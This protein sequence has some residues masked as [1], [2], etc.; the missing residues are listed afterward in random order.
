MML[1]RQSSQ[2]RTCSSPTAPLGSELGDQSYLQFMEL[3][4]IG[5]HR[6]LELPVLQKIP[7]L[8]P[9]FYL[10]RS[11]WYGDFEQRVSRAFEDANSDSNH[12]LA[13]TIRA[14]TSL[15]TQELANQFSA[16]VYFGGV[17]SMASSHELPPNTLLLISNCYLQR[18]QE[19]WDS[20]LE[21]LPARWTQGLLDRD[22][23]GSGY[24]FPFGRGPRTCIGQVFGMFFMKIALAELIRSKRLR[25]DTAQKLS[26]DYF[27]AVQHPKNLQAVFEDPSR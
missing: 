19:H 7:P 11:N 12:L 17:F 10:H 22:P 9:S 5:S 26:R 6:M 21:Y 25:I 24:F 23:L 4:K 3:A 18:C 16:P 15:N 20:P 2:P 1:W 13:K 27:F 8:S 14:G